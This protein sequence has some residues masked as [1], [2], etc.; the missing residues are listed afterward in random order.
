MFVM[1]IGSA[2]V[3]K[4]VSV[5]VRRS[6]FVIR[7]IV[8]NVVPRHSSNDFFVDTRGIMIT[9]CHHSMLL[10]GYYTIFF[11]THPPRPSS[12]CRVVVRFAAFV[13]LASRNGSMTAPFVVRAVATV[14]HNNACFFFELNSSH[15]LP[16]RVKVG[17]FRGAVVCKEC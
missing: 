8:W 11:R 4:V 17:S 7:P 2:I 10:L 15:R 6:V 16:K 9:I 5:S 14:V 12:R 3:L 1:M 13:A